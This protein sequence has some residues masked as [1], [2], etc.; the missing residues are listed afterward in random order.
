[1]IIIISTETVYVPGSGIHVVL[2][3]ETRPGEGHESAEFVALFLIVSVVYVWGGLFQQKTRE[4][5]KRNTDRVR[6][7]ERILGVDH[8][9][10]EIRV[11]YVVII[12]F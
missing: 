7:R 4:L 2:S 8:L 10:E 11:I 3:Q 9:L 6:T 5:E 1:M 12:I